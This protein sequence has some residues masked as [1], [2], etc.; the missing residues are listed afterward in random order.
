MSDHSMSKEMKRVLYDKYVAPLITTD[1]SLHSFDTLLHMAQQ[2]F[3]F[4][5][6]KIDL[7]RAVMYQ[8]VCERLLKDPAS[9]Q[10][11]IDTFSYMIKDQQHNSVEKMNAVLSTKGSSS[12][13][14]FVDLLKEYDV[15]FEVLLRD[16]LTPLYLFAS[17]YYGKKI[18]TD[19]AKAHYLAGAD[20]KMKILLEVTL[21]FDGIDINSLIKDIDQDIRNASAHHRWRLLDSNRIEINPKDKVG[22]ER[23]LTKNEIEAKL[24]QFKKVLWSMR[25]GFFTYL[26]NTDFSVSDVFYSDFSTK[27]IEDMGTTIDEKVLDVSRF[28]WS[29]GGLELSLSNKEQSHSPGGEIY[30]AEGSYDIVSCIEKL[31]FA[32]RVLGFLSRYIIYFQS[33][34]DDFKFTV[35]LTLDG[36]SYGTLIITLNELRLLNNVIKEYG[37]TEY[38]IKYIE[39]LCAQKS[40]DRLLKVEVRSDTLV[41]FGQ[42]KQTIALLKEHFGKIEVEFLTID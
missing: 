9:K 32:D 20:R 21:P 33:K 24:D 41:P 16:F 25:V 22:T 12:V 38:T 35:N 3:I 4:D 14:D 29:D 34:S 1:K 2:A 10:E 30:S 27:E 42:R 23:V 15:H 18:N 19:N 11:V 5:V 39:K 40:L 31:P 6:K 36:V 26:E 8:K 28:I 7:H 13:S 17:K 37:K